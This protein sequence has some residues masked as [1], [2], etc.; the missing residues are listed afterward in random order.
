MSKEHEFIKII[1]QA[2]IDAIQNSKPTNFYIGNVIS[3]SPLSIQL[4]QK[5]TLPEEFL[6]LTRNVTDYTLTMEVEHSTE[7]A[8]GGENEHSHPYT[9]EKEFVVKNHLIKGEKV[10]IAQVVGGQMYIV[11][12]RL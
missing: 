4:D 7:S 11:L 9:G 5:L 2:A 1:K 3:E 8:G 6:L 12:D 10:L